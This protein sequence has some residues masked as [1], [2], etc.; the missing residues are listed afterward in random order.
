MSELVQPPL[1]LWAGV[2][3]TLNRVGDHY[4]DQLALS[5]HESRLTDLDLFAALG[6]L[7]LMSVAPSA[8]RSR[9]SARSWIRTP[10]GRR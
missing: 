8:A 10:T 3:C 7:A 6:V 4:F 2:E 9:S 5:G 1:E